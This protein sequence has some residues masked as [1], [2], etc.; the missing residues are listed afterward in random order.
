MARAGNHRE[1]D[2]AK[3][4]AIKRQL[5]AGVPKAEIA[6]RLG[7]DRYTVLR[8]SNGSHVSA[9]QHRVP[10]RRCPGCGGIPKVVPCLLCAARQVRAVQAER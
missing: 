1:I 9:R 4:A 10:A 5:A 2:C 3:V 6:R 8:V 7:V